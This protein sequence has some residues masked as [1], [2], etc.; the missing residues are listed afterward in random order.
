MIKTYL[1]FNSPQCRG[2]IFMA[3]LYLWF[4]Q[5]AR[6]GEMCRVAKMETYRGEAATTDT[7]QTP[8]HVQIDQ[9]FTHDMGKLKAMAYG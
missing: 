3:F 8:F 4:W 1:F 5:R 7:R 2:I 9:G 6:K